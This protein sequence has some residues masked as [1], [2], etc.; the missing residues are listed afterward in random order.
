MQY[1]HN[2]QHRKTVLQGITVTISTT[3][4]YTPEAPHIAPSTTAERK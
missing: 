4:G 1:V 2:N 3:A